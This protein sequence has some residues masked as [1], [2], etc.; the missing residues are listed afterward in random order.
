MGSSLPKGVTGFGTPGKIKKPPSPWSFREHEEGG[1]KDDPG[2]ICHLK[3]KCKDQ[4]VWADRGSG[5]HLF[6]I[7]RKT[8]D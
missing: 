7:K 1:F 6:A 3:G 2:R 4:V 8:D 5:P